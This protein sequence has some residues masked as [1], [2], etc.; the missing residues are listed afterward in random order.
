[1]ILQ[2]ESP[3][4]EW[5]IVLLLNYS[6]NSGTFIFFSKI[7]EF[8]YRI[9][10]DLTIETVYDEKYR[11]DVSKV[12][13]T[14]DEFVN[15]SSTVDDYMDDLNNYSDIKYFKVVD[16]TTNILLMMSSDYSWISLFH[17]RIIKKKKTSGKYFI[18][19]LLIVMISGLMNYLV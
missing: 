3:D 12:S 18:L 17:S 6:L 1:M 16:Q 10:K 14:F 4:G 2:Y 8:K 5:C 13:C 7:G 9:V 19:V 11:N 15:I